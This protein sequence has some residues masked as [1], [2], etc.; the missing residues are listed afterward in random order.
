MQLEIATN[1][2]NVFVILTPCARNSYWG[3]RS[4][5]LKASWSPV[6]SRNIFW[7]NLQKRF[8]TSYVLAPRG[9]RPGSL[10]VWNKF[11][12]RTD[13]AQEMWIRTNDELIDT[14][15]EWLRQALSLLEDIDDA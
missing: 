2:A 1:M 13:L 7:T 9:G 4:N 3:Y 15:L 10:R 6:L 14:N 8:C 5:V 12:G 11:R